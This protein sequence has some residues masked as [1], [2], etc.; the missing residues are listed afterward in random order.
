MSK[1]IETIQIVDTAGFVFP[2]GTTFVSEPVYHYVDGSKDGYKDKHKDDE[3]THEKHHVVYEFKLTKKTTLKAVINKGLMAQLNIQAKA[4]K[5]REA[6]KA[7]KE[8]D[9][10]ADVWLE[11]NYAM[12]NRKVE[13]DLSKAWESKSGM[14]K[15]EKAL[16]TLKDLYKDKSAEEKAKLLAFLEE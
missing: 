2:E 10:I 12:T 3:E 9:E 15:E 13:I 5:S 1:S 14:T 11:K 4:I 7:T 6:N 8:T 16:Q